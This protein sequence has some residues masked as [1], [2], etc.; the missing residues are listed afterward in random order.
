MRA[1]H[2]AKGMRMGPRSARRATLM[3]A[4]T[5]L[6][7]SACS[8]GGQTGAGG[9]EETDTGDSTAQGSDTSDTGDPTLFEGEY[10]VSAANVR[11]DDQTGIMA[12]A[13]LA[14]SGTTGSCEKSL[15]PEPVLCLGFNLEYEYTYQ[16]TFGPAKGNDTIELVHGSL[17]ESVTCVDGECAVGADGQL[18]ATNAGYEIVWPEPYV[19]DFER[20]EARKLEAICG[21]SAPDAEERREV[22]TV[23]KGDAESIQSFSYP[24]RSGG[25]HTIGEEECGTYYIVYD[26]VLTRS[27]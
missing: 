27:S 22:V 5:A 8:S 1:K 19:D 6:I 26:V 9:V 25:A 24:T 15:H 7:L 13:V 4:L 2:V 12:D 14:P 16:A 18:S 21:Q 20:R 11:L 23:I 17:S 3:I 10:T